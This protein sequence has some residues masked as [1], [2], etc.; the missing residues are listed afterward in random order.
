[1]ENDAARSLLDDLLARAKALGAD[2]ADAMIVNSTALSHADRLGKT[3]LLERS[4]SRDLGLRVFFGKR[5]AVVS[6]NDWKAATLDDLVERAV[7]MAKA[8]PQDPYCGLADPDQLFRGAVLDL[9]IF[10]PGEPAAKTLIERART[11]EAAARDVSGVTN[12]EGAEASWSGTSVMIAASNG[13]SGGYAISRHG[14]GVSVIAGEGSDMESD[15]EFSSVV[16][17]DDL[18]DPASVGRAAGMRAVKRL[19]PRKGPTVKVPVVYD[20][21]VANGIIGHFAGAINGAAIARGTS[22]LKDAMDTKVFTDGVTIIDDPHRLRG[23]RS[24][25]FDA[26]GLA[27]DAMNLIE[28]GV[29]TRWILD[30][31]ASRQLGLGSTGRATRGVSGPPSPSTTNLYMAPGRLTPAALIADIE[32]GFYVTG[33]MGFGIDGLTGDYSRGASGFWIEGGEIAYPISEM[34]IAG[35]LKDMFAN[36]TPADDLE[37]R[38]GSNAPTL[39]IDGMTVAGE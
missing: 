12:S 26:E 24:K 5:Q 17:G 35:N 20:P 32:S 36:L 8:V 16:H 25:P 6:S 23:L 3:E 11:T 39:R 13:F 14:I 2:A 29:L 19:N 7:A 34:T 28:D 9:D 37:F 21:R 27:N 18:D 15:Y 30:L 10:D 4:E 22:F 33:L 1:M 38:Y 31:R